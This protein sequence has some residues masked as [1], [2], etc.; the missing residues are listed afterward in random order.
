M[1]ATAPPS[2]TPAPP[3]HSPF[4]SPESIPESICETAL[5]CCLW[6]AKNLPR[7]E[8][9]QNT[10]QACQDM[11]SIKEL[12]EFEREACLL[13]IRGW[14]QML[15]RSGQKVPPPCSIR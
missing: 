6:I 1:R 5:A 13:A 14:N 7:S 15:E 10:A 11:E 3:S 4:P 12:G 9:A 8:Q 2:P